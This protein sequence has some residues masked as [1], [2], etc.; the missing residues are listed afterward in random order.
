MLPG[1]LRLQAHVRGQVDRG[2]AL[3]GGG[4]RLSRH[5][6]RILRSPGTGLHHPEGPVQR[7]GL[8]RVPGPQHEQ[9][10][11]RRPSGQRQQAAEGRSEGPEAD[12]EK[13]VQPRVV[14]VRPKLGRNIRQH[15]VIRW[16]RS[17]HG[18]GVQTR[19]EQ[20]ASR[21]L[22]GAAAGGTRQA[23]AAIPVSSRTG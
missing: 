8:V 10:R 22:H 11:L 4:H 6:A 2:D 16:F 9:A 20:E 18:P 17:L 14:R 5:R 3:Q 13:V 21:G 1:R 12:A 7:G 23:R 19:Q 15:S